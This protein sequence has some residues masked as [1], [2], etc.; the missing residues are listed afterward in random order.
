M[1][2]FDKMHGNGN[3]FIVMNSIEQEFS[4]NKRLIK[5]LSDRNL[6][7][8][9]DQLILVDSPKKPDSDFFIRFYNADGGQANLC[10]NGIR[11][12]ATYIWNKNLA[13]LGVLNFQTKKR[14]VLCEPNKNN[15][16]VTI[17][18]PKTFKNEKLKKLLSSKLKTSEF[19][20]IDA[21]NMH[22][23]IKKKSIKAIDINSLYQK[24][25][26]IIK[27]FEINLTIYETNKNFICVRTYENGVGETLSC[28]S[29]SLSVASLFLETEFKKICIKSFGGELK[30]INSDKNISMIGPSESVYSGSINE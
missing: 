9:F 11:C 12:A 25:E 27:P 15:V 30:F 22:L 7:I 5:K 8:G 16:K 19:N 4:P 1:I 28:G 23:C 13:P 2:N 14:H 18:R 17:N 10:L 21:G 3:D 26:K 6:G 24:L 29:A 20:L